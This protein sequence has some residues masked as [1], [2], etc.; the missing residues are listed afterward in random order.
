ML[1][2]AEHHLRGVRSEKDLHLQLGSHL[3]RGA[4]VLWTEHQHHGLR[5]AIGLQMTEADRLTHRFPEWIQI[6][7][8]RQA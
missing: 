6:S 3:P 7:K 1:L 8:G 5:Y 2:I 4:K